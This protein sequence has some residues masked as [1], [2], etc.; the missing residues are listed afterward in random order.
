MPTPVHLWAL[1]EHP[2]VLLS[3]RSVPPISKH[4]NLTDII[5]IGVGC[6]K[7]LS[8]LTLALMPTL[9]HLGV[10]GEQPWVSLVYYKVCPS[11]CGYWILGSKQWL[12]VWPA[13]GDVNVGACGRLCHTRFSCA[14]LLYYNIFV[15]TCMQ[16]Q[17]YLVTS[18]TG[19]WY[20]ICNTDTMCDS[21]S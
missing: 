21:D 4:E 2:H 8:T 19:K 16:I 9:V 1:W 13:N 10:Q 20:V 11:F 7:R 17:N 14:L 3:T 5:K 12:I 6:H 18:W 15:S